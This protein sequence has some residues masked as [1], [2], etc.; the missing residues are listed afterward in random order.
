MTAKRVLQERS[1]VV[2]LVV[3]IT[4]V[5]LGSVALIVWVGHRRA[6][7]HYEDSYGERAGQR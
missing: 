5:V 6:V 3:T 4:V 1:K 7:E 2:M